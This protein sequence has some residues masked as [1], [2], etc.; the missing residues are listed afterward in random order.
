MPNFIPVVKPYLKR[1]RLEQIVKKAEKA[2]TKELENYKEAGFESKENYKA[3]LK[4]RDK[5][6]AIVQQSAQNFV[7]TQKQAPKM[8]ADIEKT[9]GKNSPEADFAR[10]AVSV[11]PHVTFESTLKNESKKLQAV[12]PA[13]L[14]MPQS[15]KKMM[16]LKVGVGLAFCAVVG[17]FVRGQ[18]NKEKELE[19]G[20]EITIDPNLPANV[21]DP[22]KPQVS[23]TVVEE[24]VKEGNDLTPEQVKNK[25]TEVINSS[26]YQKQATDLAEQTNVKLEAILKDLN[27]SYANMEEFMDKNFSGVRDINLVDKGG[28]DNYQNYERGEDESVVTYIVR[29]L[30]HWKAYQESFNGPVVETFKSDYPNLFKLYE[31]NNIEINAEN[32]FSPLDFFAYS[33]YEKARDLDYEQTGNSFFEYVNQ[34]KFYTLMNSYGADDYLEK[35]LNN[36]TNKL[37]E[38]QL[39]EFEK[40]LQESNSTFED[41]MTTINDYNTGIAELQ[42]EFVESLVLS[43][44]DEDII[45]AILV[46]EKDSDQTFD[47]LVEHLTNQKQQSNTLDSIADASD[48][49]ID[50][51][52]DALDDALSM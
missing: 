26:D 10:F 13:T 22:T 49:V 14:K 50:A 20:P 17:A 41:Y 5:S 32:I 23:D 43:G 31:D 12:T 18:I 11:A 40:L 39:Q 46:D 15:K 8:I 35:C 27:Q 6:S 4:Q 24:I 52:S 9:H 51:V 36:F 3:F 2:Q 19:V 48:N 33:T 28:F 45:T 7:K 42:K 30:H 21:V 29:S 25:V 37:S 47:D 16:A 38:D 34:P 44:Y 1:R